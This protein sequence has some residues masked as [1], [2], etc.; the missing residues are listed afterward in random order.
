MPGTMQKCVWNVWSTMSRKSIDSVQGSA[1][2]STQWR[3]C[4][5]DLSLL[6]RMKLAR[7]LYYWK[8][9]L[10]YLGLYGSR[11]DPSSRNS[12][13]KNVYRIPHLHIWNPALSYTETIYKLRIVPVGLLAL[14][15]NC[16]ITWFIC[17]AALVHNCLCV[18]WTTVSLLFSS[19]NSSPGK[20]KTRRLWNSLTKLEKLE[21]FPDFWTNSP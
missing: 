15:E 12:D 9:N 21:K 17:S 1:N 16:L 11:N 18:K 14:Q 7:R 5:G 10:A 2:V 13:F 3:S 8:M 20:K 4:I 19:A 6:W